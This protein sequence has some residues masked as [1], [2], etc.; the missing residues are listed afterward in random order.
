MLHLNSRFRYVFA[1]TRL[2]VLWGYHMRLMLAYDRNCFD[3]HRLLNKSA[4]ARHGAGSHGA[5]I[6]G[7]RKLPLLLLPLLLLAP[8]APT[9]APPAIR[10]DPGHGPPR[11]HGRGLGLG[12]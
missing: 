4:D 11:W 1:P 3:M 8:P 10:P 6:I 5:D 9:A 7:G 2:S 12:A